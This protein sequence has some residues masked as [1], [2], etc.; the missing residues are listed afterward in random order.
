MASEHSLA[1]ESASSAG[2][3][4]SPAIHLFEVVLFLGLLFGLGP[5]LQA[6]TGP[7]ILTLFQNPLFLCILW[8]GFLYA[9]GGRPL[10]IGLARERNRAQ[11]WSGGKLALVCFAVTLG[12]FA[13]NLFAEPVLDKMAVTHLGGDTLEQTRK[14]EFLQGDPVALAQWLALIWLFAALGEE[15]FFRGFLQS[16]MEQMLGGGTAASIAALVGQAVV[17]G[18][19]HI[20]DG[21]VAVVGTAASGL[22]LGACFLLTGRRL[23]PV[24]IAHGL[25]D[26][27]GLTMLF[28]G[29]FSSSG[30]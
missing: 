13:W 15:L 19:H 1:G 5:L 8:F 30:S 27:F 29:V 26:S 3:A 23:L 25:W 11:P 9:R 12:F 10:D 22:F 24:I 20:E 14:Y 6:T 4:G 16:R 21:S 28:L 17:F 7:S 2:K 18:F